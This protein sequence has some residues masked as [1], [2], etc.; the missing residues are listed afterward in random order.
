VLRRR[1]H[2]EPAP[3]PDRH[4][5]HAIEL[6]KRFAACFHDVRRQHLIEHE[7]VTPVGERG[8]GIALG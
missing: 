5:G 6:T 3:L 8:F 2:P 1:P 7:V 4:P